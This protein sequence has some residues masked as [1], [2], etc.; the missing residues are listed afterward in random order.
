MG[1]RSLVEDLLVSGLD[2]PA[3]A[4]WVFGLATTAGLVSRSQLRQLS[5]GIISEVICQGLM[6]PGDHDRD[7]HHPWDCA[8]GAAIERITREWILDWSDEVPTPGA[9]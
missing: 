5:I 9:I 4:A 7:G 8:A 2:D 3:Y 6:V 1:E